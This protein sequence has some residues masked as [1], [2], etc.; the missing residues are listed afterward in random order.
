MNEKVTIGITDC[1]KFAN[2]Q[3]WI[4]DAGAAVIKLSQHEN[5]FADLE[6]CDGIL[7]S[8]GEDVHP[9]FYNKPEYLELCQE[10]DE[11]R[12]EFELKVLDHATQHNLPLLGICRG[13]QVANVFFGGTLIPHIPAFGKFNHS[14]TESHDRYHNVQV[15]EDSQLRK[16]T[17]EISGEVNSA[18]HQSADRIAKG[19]IANA[20]SSDGVVEGLEREDP[21]RG[22]FLQ[23]V[24]W[25]PERMNNLQSAFS[26]KIKEKFLEACAVRNK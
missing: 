24:Q 8:G 12:D 17:G 19:L 7:L 18:H 5:N 9:R 21:E 14:R 11:K 15:A 10:I 3:R 22:S 1:G 6:R 16:M 2:Y 13:L 4:E 26:L 23:L 20:L 25:H